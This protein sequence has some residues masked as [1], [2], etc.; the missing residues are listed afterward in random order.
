M[1][2]YDLNIFYREEWD[3]ANKAAYHTNLLS[4][5]VYIY[6]SDGNG[7]RKYETG[8]IIDCDEFET[9]EIAKQFSVE[10]YGMDWWVNLGE[11]TIPT[12]RILRLLKDLPDLSELGN[13][14]PDIEISDKPVTMT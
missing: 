1:R 11:F 10:D 14:N 9:S 5:E 13:L 6:E 3:E 12:I 7:V 8:L 2:T 4:I